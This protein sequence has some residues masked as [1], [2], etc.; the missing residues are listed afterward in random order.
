[1]ADGLNSD[2]MRRKPSFAGNAASRPARTGRR[3]EYPVNQKS[4]VKQTPADLA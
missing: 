3:S 1:M 2:G 4:L